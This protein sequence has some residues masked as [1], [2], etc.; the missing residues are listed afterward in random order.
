MKPVTLKD[1]ALRLGVDVSLVS[2]VLRSDPSARVSA[3]TRK[4]ILALASSSGYK[5]NRV[6]RSLRTQ[7]STVIALVVPD[8]TNPFYSTLFRAVE[9]AALAEGYTVILCNIDEQSERFDRLLDVF[10]ETYVDGWLIATSRDSD[11]YISAL[12]QKGAEL[13]LINRRSS[14]DHV[15]WIGPDDPAAGEMGARHLLELGH[16]RVVYVTADLAIKSMKTRL[17]GFSAVWPEFSTRFKK[18]WVLECDRSEVRHL[19]SQLLSVPAAKRPTAFFVSNSVM[20]EGIWA[21][22]RDAG[23]RIPQ[24]VSLVTYNLTPDANFSG[25]VVPVAEIGRLGVARLIAKLKGPK[26]ASE[27][28]RWTFPVSFIDHGTTAPPPQ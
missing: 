18:K 3:A 16:R 19:A 13:V 27:A 8:I 11:G 7:Q 4:R 22:V 1:L 28:A 23:L 9:S 2:R 24:D 12:Q 21:A 6:A 14:F 25:V 15:D 26:G 20:L 17:G 10:G 5:P